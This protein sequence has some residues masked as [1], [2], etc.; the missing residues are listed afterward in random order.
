MAVKEERRARVQKIM[1]G[2]DKKPSPK[3]TAENLLPTKPGGGARITSEQVQS[4]HIVNVKLGAV[5]N[6]LKDQLVL[7]KVREGLRKRKA[8]NERRKA[9]DCLLY[10]S[11]SPR[12]RG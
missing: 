10:T 3:I 11:P 6:G 4:L 7:S 2:G 5:S 12:D 1:G 8:E 9:R